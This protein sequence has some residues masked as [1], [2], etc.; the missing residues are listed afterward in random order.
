ME[1]DRITLFNTL[2]FGIFYDSTINKVCIEIN[3]SQNGSPIGP[4][5]YPHI[6]HIKATPTIIPIRSFAPAAPSASTSA[7]AAAT[8]PKAHHV[9]VICDQCDKDIHGFRY[10]C[11]E[12][13]DYDL[14]MECEAKMKHS[15]HM[16]LR[17]PD[18]KDADLVSS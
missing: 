16:M 13:W 1:G 14:C 17:I 7:R 18:P 2:D 6:P 12:C 4:A 8:P 9:N 3:Q 5:K 15:E 10:K 11:M